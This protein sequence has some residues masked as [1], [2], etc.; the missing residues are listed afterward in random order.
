MLLITC[1]SQGTIEIYEFSDPAVSH[2]GPTCKGIFKLP[3]LQPLRNYVALHANSYPLVNRPWVSNPIPPLHTPLFSPSPEDRICVVHIP[4]INDLGHQF[5]S[6]LFIH[7][8]VFFGLDSEVSAFL[9]ESQGDAIPWEI[10]GPQNTRWY[11]ADWSG[12]RYS[13]YGLKVIDSISRISD[14]DS[15][16]RRIRLR[17]FNSRAFAPLASDDDATLEPWRKGT[18]IK[19]SSQ[20][21]APTFFAGNVET[22]LPYREV[23][24]EE[25]FDFSEV[26]MDENQIVLLKVLLIILLVCLMMNLFRSGWLV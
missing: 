5:T 20:I 10:W 9:R 2:S 24:T 6:S 7:S 26:I 22:R 3:L 25:I 18:V 12:W 19:E 8:R 16:D 1:P 21:H 13:S 4:L 17:D 15:R 14:M 11:P 23:L